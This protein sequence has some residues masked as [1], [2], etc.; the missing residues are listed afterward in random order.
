MFKKIIFPLILCCVAYFA[1]A[2][3]DFLE[4]EQ[5][6]RFSVAET[7]GN[8][9]RIHYEIAPGY[10]MY[11]EQFKVDSENAEAVEQ[12]QLPKAERKFDKA[13]NEYLDVYHNAVD[14]K[15]RLKSG[16]ERLKLTVTGQGCADA[17]LC[18]P[19]MQEDIWLKSDGQGGYQLASKPKNLFSSNPSEPVQVS[20]VKPDQER[21]DLLSSNDQGIADYLSQAS[22]WQ[23]LLVCFGLGLILSFTPCVLPMLPILLSIIVGQQQTSSKSVRGFTLTLMYVLGMS[24]VYMALGLLAASLGVA[25][26]SWLQNPW[27]LSIFALFLFVFALAMFDVFTLQ[28]PSWIQTKLNARIDRLGKGR[29]ISTFMMGMLSSLVVGPCIAA[30]LAGI[31]LFIAQTGN[32]W[33]G[34][35]A[36]FTLAWGQGALLL[37]LGLS[38]GKL[39]PR[40]GQWLNQV[41]WV[42]GMLL[43]AVALWLIDPLLPSALSMGL[44]AGILVA[45]ATVL[46]VFTPI[47]EMRLSTLLLRVLGVLMLIWAMLLMIGLATGSHQL[48][49]PLDRLLVGSTVAPV[50]QSER[51]SFESVDNLTELNRVLA[52]TSEPVLLDFYADWCVSCKEME[53]FTFTDAK[54]ATLMS[55][56]RLL[57]VDMTDVTEAYRS[58][59]RQFNLFGPPAILVFK[60]GELNARIVGFEN[61]STFANSLQKVLN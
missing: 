18:Y 54:V 36:L 48:F 58:L 21:F 12:L 32:M 57:R 22:L 25:L 61:A 45:F 13:F 44:W 8:D 39:M 3:E 5:A 15:V 26:S 52:S 17:G 10:Y 19:P 33:L 47:V 38:S 20:E 27:V 35:L 55:Q 60:Q 6:F 23:V 43:L 53:Q 49:R 37:L 2:T 34:A 7:Q 24:V 31:L 9:V 28:M 50:A 56:M 1:Y 51:L 46:G 40:M 29:Y 11:R 41:K 14:L 4:P 59:L 42:C 16:H 30:P